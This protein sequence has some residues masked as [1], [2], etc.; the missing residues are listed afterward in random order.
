M[1]PCVISHAWS[2]KSPDKH[3]DKTSFWPI[4]RFC[5]ALRQ[6]DSPSASTIDLLHVRQLKYSLQGFGMIV[7]GENT[8]W[9]CSL[10]HVLVTC[11]SLLFCSQHLGL[12]SNLVG[13]SN[14]KWTSLVPRAYCGTACCRKRKSEYCSSVLCCL[15]GLV[16]IINILSIIVKPGVHSG[17]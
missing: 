11:S 6:N 17:V 15:K 16:F 5:G 7:S 2:A 4:F 8:M 13:V 1:S 9:L 3:P 10:L 12:K 14:T